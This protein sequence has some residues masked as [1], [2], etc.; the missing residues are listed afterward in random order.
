MIHGGH[1]RRYCAP[2]MNQDF[3]FASAVVQLF[4]EC[5]RMT[6]QTLCRLIQENF[7]PKNML[8]DSSQWKVYFRTTTVC[9]HDKPIR[10]FRLL[11]QTC[12]VLN[13]PTYIIANHCICIIAE[14]KNHLCSSIVPIVIHRLQG[15]EFFPT[16]TQFLAKMNPSIIPNISN[17]KDRKKVSQKA[18]E[19]A[20]NLIIH[21]ILGPKNI[22]GDEKFKLMKSS[23]AYFEGLNKH[24][25]E[26][27][28]FADMENKSHKT[29]KE[30]SREIGKYFFP[31]CCD[32][33]LDE[34][35]IT[36]MDALLKN[37]LDDFFKYIE[38]KT[39]NSTK[40]NA[41]KLYLEQV[42]NDWMISIKANQNHYHYDEKSDT[43]PENGMYELIMDN[44]DF[45]RYDLKTDYNDICYHVNGRWKSAKNNQMAPTLP[46]LFSDNNDRQCFAYFICATKKLY[47]LG[48]NG[49]LCW[50]RQYRLMYMRKQLWRSEKHIVSMNKNVMFPV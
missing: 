26:L 28:N 4:E 45:F 22:L 6:L 30:K 9:Q 42:Y 29:L 3:R 46:D 10:M 38:D 39:Q 21:N 19:I 43:F 48:T 37:K 47:P 13:I 12:P 14:C 25:K 23:I 32:P 1:L 49:I 33:K 36:A 20:S 2:F 15:S 34:A 5:P 17:K 8:V 7:E 24:F 11:D 31:F 41:S 40:I 50:L 18:I 16:P 44:N 35:Q 27:Y